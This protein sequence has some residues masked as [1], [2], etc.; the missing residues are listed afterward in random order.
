MVRRFRRIRSTRSLRDQML[1]DFEKEAEK[2]LKQITEQF[3]RDLQQQADQTL[4]DAT[5]GGSSAGGGGMGGLDL[6][7][8]LTRIF[9]SAL[10]FFLTR[11]RTS[12]STQETQRSKDYDAEFRLSRGQVLAEAQRSLV[13]GQK[14]T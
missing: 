2:L 3:L 13:R 6:G 7:G 4:K 8:S 11:P 10:T 14:N 5:R 1:R 9:G 12:R